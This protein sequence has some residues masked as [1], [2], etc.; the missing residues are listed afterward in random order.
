ME[1]IA[2]APVTPPPVN[3]A[4]PP[5]DA[6]E[7]E[8]SK[9]PGFDEAL[10]QEM[11]ALKPDGA[12]PEDPAS[13]EAEAVAAAAA[14]AAEAAALRESAVAADPGLAQLAGL[15]VPLQPA[16][17]SDA[18]GALASGASATEADQAI[19]AMGAGRP[20]ELLAVRAS[21]LERGRIEQRGLEQN[22]AQRQTLDRVNSRSAGQDAL[23]A[24]DA[25]ITQTDSAAEAH[26]AAFAAERAMAPEMPSTAGH[27]ST[28]LE[29]LSA[30]S[31]L[32]KWGAPQAGVAD[33]APAAASARIETPLG[34]A[35]WG[36][37]FQQKIVW[38]VDRQQQSAELHVNPPHLG[39]VEIMLNIDDEG[40]RIAFC[41][42]HASV[43]EAI[44]ASLPDLRASLAERGLSLG[45]AMVGADSGAAREQLAEESRNSSGRQ[46]RGAPAALVADAPTAQLARR[47]LVD[48]FA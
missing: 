3:E 37:A 12:K 16:V 33:A 14:A 46:E 47:G 2:I 5:R 10:R 11:A 30:T 43:R 6:R 13:A 31:L 45:E 41:S 22:T 15:P 29:G 25:L 26:F 39:P 23:Q 24:D 34:S 42:P 48:I 44:E 40:A 27:S 36:D 17:A 28:P 7:D 20:G 32:T 18:A 38:L 4:Q 21:A 19:P 9:N 1:T 35:G 8:V